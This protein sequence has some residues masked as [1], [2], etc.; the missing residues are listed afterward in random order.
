MMGFRPARSVHL[1]WD[2]TFEECRWLQIDVEPQQV[3]PGT[4][5]CALG[6]SNG[7]C[8]LQ[9]LPDGRHVAIFSVW[10]AAPHDDPTAVPHDQQ[11]SVVDAGDF[12]NSLQ[13]AR[14]GNEGSGCRTILPFA[15]RVGGRYRFVVREEIWNLNH[16]CYGCW[17]SSVDESYT[18]KMIARI[19]VPSP[20]GALKGVYSFVEDF[21]RRGFDLH[22]RC[23][24][25]PF[26]AMERN[27][28]GKVKSSIRATF[29][30]ASE[31]GNNIGAQIEEYRG[32]SLYSG[33]SVSSQLCMPPNTTLQATAEFKF[34]YHNLPWEMLA[35]VTQDYVTM[36]GL[37]CHVG[38]ICI[39]RSISDDS[40]WL[41]AIDIVSEKEGWVPRAACAL[42]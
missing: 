13:I 22:H 3:V 4:Y 23:L 17:I 6:W 16:A 28:C 2:T 8:G 41:C 35:R 5:F 38:D 20:V 34:R 30:A 39:I 15:W 27:S 40:L 42:I 21:G 7:Y 24:F 10:D 31:E 14:F 19:A 29:T 32:I 1:W 25:G 9:M 12:G 36:N 37:H 11:S 33:G 26:R 18:W